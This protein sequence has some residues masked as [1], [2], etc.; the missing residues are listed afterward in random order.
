MK[1]RYIGHSVVICIWRTREH[2]VKI[3]ALSDWYGKT[4]LTLYETPYFASVAKHVFTIHGDS[5][6]RR[7]T[8]TVYEKVRQR[9]LKRKH[10]IP[11]SL[12]HMFCHGVHPDCSYIK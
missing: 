12:L 8:R 1:W 5:Y 7:G 6:G 10:H 4:S 3:V 2:E 11:D 9:F